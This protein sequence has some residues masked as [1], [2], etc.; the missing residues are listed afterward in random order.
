MQAN[1]DSGIII[2]GIDNNYSVRGMKIKYIYYIDNV[3][4]VNWVIEYAQIN[5]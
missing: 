5:Q 4:H 3:Q 1:S 2:Y